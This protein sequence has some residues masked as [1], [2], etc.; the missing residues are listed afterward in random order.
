[1]KFT[2]G[3]I[4]VVALNRFNWESVLALSPAEDQKGN[5]PDILFSI[6]QSKFENCVPFGIFEKGEVRGFI[7]FCIFQ[8]VAW[9]NRI[10]IDKEHQNLGIGK[11]ALKL[12]LSHLRTRPDVREVRTSMA[13][14]NEIAIRLFSNAGFVS[15]GEED[16]KEIVMRWRG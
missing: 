10:L 6:A 8:N 15:I 11:I 12:I 1:M 4:E 14:G 5:I 13:S 2:F 3:E 7:M 16:E 9:V